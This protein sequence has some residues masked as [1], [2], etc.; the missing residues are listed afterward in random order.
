[1][2]D[3]TFLDKEKTS[4]ADLHSD[5]SSEDLFSI[6]ELATKFLSHCREKS[7]IIKSA[8]NVFHSLLLTKD[9][10]TTVK[11]KKENQTEVQTNQ[12]IERLIHFSYINLICTGFIHRK[13]LSKLSQNFLLLILFP[14]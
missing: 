6:E 9:E 1:M 11:L 10:T 7:L 4:N 2:I 3:L 14:T 8:S 12:Q 13:V 5:I